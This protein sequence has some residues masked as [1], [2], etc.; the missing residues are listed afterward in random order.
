[1][2]LHVI[3][4]GEHIHET[5]TTTMKNLNGITDV[6]VV[7]EENIYAENSS[8]SD[9]LK[10]TKP[11]IREAIS[12]VRKICETL[13]VN[14]HLIKIPNT[15][16]LSVRDAILLSISNNSAESRLSFNLSGGTK[17]LSLSLFVMAIWLDGE[18]YLTPSSSQLEE[19]LIPKMHLNDVRKNPNYVN[20]LKIL[21]KNSKSGSDKKYVAEWMQGRDFSRIMKEE[22]ERVRFPGDNSAKTKPNRGSITKIVIPLEEWGLI[23]ERY[24]PG[25]RRDKEYRLSNDGMFALSILQSE[26]R[27]KKIDC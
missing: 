8:D 7:V 21:G 6:G 9:Y 23:E 1:M 16:L 15:S 14:F 24:R 13:S 3:S 18:I 26:E 12:E 5:F 27:N 19:L 4:A 22:Y 10:I 11:R 17:M 25:S 2:H 20:A